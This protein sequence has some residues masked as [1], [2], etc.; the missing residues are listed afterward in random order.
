[1]SN[2]IAVLVCG[3]YRQFD[4]AVK[5]WDFL[6]KYDF[7]FSLWNTSH[8]YNEKLNINF[9]EN[10]DKEKITNFI[11]SSY[12]E[13]YDESIFSEKSE[14]LNKSSNFKNLFHWK[15]CLN[16]LLSNNKEY[17]G[18]ILMRPDINLN[19]NKDISDINFTNKILIANNFKETSNQ[20]ELFVH[21]AMIVGSFESIKF[22]IESFHEN[23]PLTHNTIAKK[24]INSNFNVISLNDYVNFQIVRP[25]VRLYNEINSKIIDK[26]YVEWANNH[27][28][29]DILFLDKK[30][31]DN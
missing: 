2:K 6:L 17:D 29:E 10:I 12:I 21:D 1:M 26:C 23:E 19:L 31:N 3:E 7:Y 8:Q 24:V 18:I 22:L 16:L 9:F 4:I 25:N 20:D 27:C 13:L 5:S 15:S 14:L 30:Y 28:E 11:E